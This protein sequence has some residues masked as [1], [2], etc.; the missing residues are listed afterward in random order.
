MLSRR[1][2][3]TSLALVLALGGAASAGARTRDQESGATPPRLSFIDGEVSFWRPGADD[4]AP[5]QVNTPLAEGDSL[6][7]GDGGNLELQVGPRGF[8]RAG[9][10]TEIGLES[11]DTDLVQFKVTAGHAAV[12]ARTLPR[13][14]ALEVDT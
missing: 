11:L 4:W 7:T 12:D 14:Q 8:V 2:F 1:L 13:G 10:G 5:A 9:S 6:Y 3:A